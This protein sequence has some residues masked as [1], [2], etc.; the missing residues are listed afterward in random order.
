MNDE[1][2]KMLKGLSDE[3][4]EAVMKAC[5]YSKMAGDPNG[6]DEGDM[7]KSL[8]AVEDAILAADELAEQPS[9]LERLEANDGVSMAKSL[10][11]TGFLQGIVTEVSGALDGQGSDIADLRKAQDITNTALLAIG[12]FV[13][14]MQKSQ[15]D[16]SSEITALREA[17]EQP[18]AVR[19]STTGPGAEALSKAFGA[20]DGGGDGKGSALSKAAVKRGLDMAMTKAFS[21]DDKNEVHRIGR[22]ATRFEST[23]QITPEGIAL[24]Q[25]ELKAAGV[26]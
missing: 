25:S 11:A 6:A 22:L 26:G 1:A 10:D 20:L 12:R 21:G 14:R 18:V 17:L 24:A 19:G 15:A 13:E 9:A 23:G 2:F 7:K 3:D 16:T 8:A 4:R 5:G